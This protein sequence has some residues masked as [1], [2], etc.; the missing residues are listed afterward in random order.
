M[1]NQVIGDFGY[2]KTD[3][4]SLRFVKAETAGEG[5]SHSSRFTRLTRFYYG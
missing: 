3:L 4:P 1:P 2:H 5:K